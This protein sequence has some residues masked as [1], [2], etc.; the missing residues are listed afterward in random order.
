M[1]SHCTHDL[2][3]GRSPATPHVE[4]TDQR[5]SS[6]SRQSGSAASASFRRNGRAGAEPSDLE[7]ETVSALAQSASAFAQPAASRP[8]LRCQQEE[9]GSSRLPVCLAL[10]RA[11]DMGFEP[12]TVRFKI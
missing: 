9:P 7:P 2:P 6:G 12:I 1:H 5:L 10:L 8:E 4:T 11:V 3:S